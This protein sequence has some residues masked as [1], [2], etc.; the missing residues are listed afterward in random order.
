GGGAT[1]GGVAAGGAA[2]GAAATRTQG[3]DLV[4]YNLSTT[5]AVNVG[6][7]AE[8]GFDDSGD[9]VAYSVDARD[10]IGNG[11]QLRNMRTAVVRPID[12]DRALYRRLAWADSAPALVVLRGR[13]DSTTRDTVYSVVAFTDFAGSSPKKN[14]F[15][16]AQRTDF[17]VGMKVS[18]D[19]APRFAGDLSAVLCGIREGRKPGER[20]LA[21]RGSSVIQAGAPGMG[22]SNNQPRVHEAQEENPSLTLSHW[23]DPRLP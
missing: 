18:P 10:Q 8:F 19:R 4:L 17:P 3:T 6:N 5:D 20:T 9:W 16:A 23:Q 15:D 12:S 11:V 7:V 13:A 14:V 22:G 1:G 21:G 2:G